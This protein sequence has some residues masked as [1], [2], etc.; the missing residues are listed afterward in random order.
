MTIPVGFEVDVTQPGRQARRKKNA[1]DP[2]GL[3]GMKQQ[4]PSK[5]RDS[6]RTEDRLTSIRSGQADDPETCTVFNSSIRSDELVERFDGS[7]QK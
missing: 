4:R 5:P 7:W 1:S 2:G 3:N 6:S